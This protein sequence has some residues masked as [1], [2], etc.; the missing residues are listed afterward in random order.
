MVH[1]PFQHC[2]MA[3]KDYHLSLSYPSD[4]FAVAGDLYTALHVML[5]YATE[6]QAP[7]TQDGQGVGGVQVPIAAPF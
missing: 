3:Q 6:V 4:I 5:Q 1:P 2:S 7:H